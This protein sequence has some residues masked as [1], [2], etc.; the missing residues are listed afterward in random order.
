MM[1]LAT[2]CI[3]IYRE[4]VNFAILRLCKKA[5]ISISNWELDWLSVLPLCHF[6]SGSCEPFA[7]LEYNPENIQFNARAKEFGYV[8]VRQ[9]LSL[10]YVHMHLRSNPD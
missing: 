8:D 9:K 1:C 10:G 7:S 2:C 4:K 3:F 6:L 5:M